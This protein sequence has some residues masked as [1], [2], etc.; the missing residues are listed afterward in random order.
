MKTHPNTIDRCF[1]LP[2]K[3]LKRSKVTSPSFADIASSLSY[4]AKRKPNNIAFTY[5]NDGEGQEQSLTFYEL[6]QHACKVAKYLSHLT[7]Q[8]SV[9]IL[10][11]SEMRFI[12]SF[13][14]CQ[15]AG[16]IAVPAYP[17]SGKE[18]SKRLAAII[19]DSESST[20]ISSEEIKEKFLKWSQ[21]VK[22]SQTLK[23]LTLKEST[24][25]SYEFSN[26]PSQSSLD[27]EEFPRAITTKWLSFIQYTSGSTGEPKGVMVSHENVV[28][29]Q[30]MIKEVFQHS[31]ST[32]FAGWLPLHHD[33]G[34][35]GNVLQP[36]YLGIS[37]Y[38]MPPIA[39]IQKPI[40]WLKMI[41]KYQATTSGGPNFAYHLCN[42]R[43]TQQQKSGLNLSCWQVAFNGAEPVKASTIETFYKEF[44]PY[45]LK[46]ESLFPVYGMAEATLLASGGDVQQIPSIVNVDIDTL[47]EGEVKIHTNLDNNNKKYKRMVSC[48]KAPKGQHIVIV[49][50][51]SKQR[52]SEDTVGE[53]WLSGDNVATGYRNRPDINPETFN[54]KISNESDEGHP[55]YL[56]T[57]DLGFIANG[58]L[59]ITGRIKDIIIVCGVNYYPQDI[60]ATIESFSADF[61]DNATAVFTVNVGD[62]ESVVAVQEIERSALKSFSPETIKQALRDRVSEEHEISLKQVCFVRPMSLPKTTSGKIQRSQCRE[63]FI[64][65]ELKQVKQKNK[66]QAITMLQPMYVKQL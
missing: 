46:E 18:K 30:Q 50:P 37:C 29:N 49:D 2:H 64:N 62:S 63:L 48:G 23:W 21:D 20:I 4:H 41:S 66:K 38:L 26:N 22:L 27:K 8:T 9:I 24:Y 15:Y 65:G 5:L 12:V 17:P 25:N 32:V 1:K 34:L 39:F 14:A 43:I 11:H 6:H 45:G 51:V 13:M 53:I 56:R 52:L 7:P 28:S 59:F 35:V 31:S 33:M 57:G 54:V 55:S 58:E 40:R 60:E 19:R 47:A 16:L 61:I 44:S 36:I 10:L 3:G 42:K